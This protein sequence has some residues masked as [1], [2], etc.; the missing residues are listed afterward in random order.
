M[1]KEELNNDNSYAIQDIQN[2]LNKKPKI[3]APIDFIVSYWEKKKW[4]TKKGKRVKNISALVNV[5]NS[6][7]LEKYR[8]EQIRTLKRERS[9]KA[10]ENKIRNSSVKIKYAEQLK[11]PQWKAYREF[12]L[13]VR[14]SKCEVC[15]GNKNINIHHKHYIKGRLAW[16]YLPNDVMVLCRSCHAKVHNIKEK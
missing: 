6:C 16:E 12:I 13:V 9:V 14:G 2:Y 3:V 8:R 5:A 10:K 7:Y 15:G 11:T 4:L 1:N